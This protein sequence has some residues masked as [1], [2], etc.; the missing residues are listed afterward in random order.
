MNQ[1]TNQQIGFVACSSWT[2]VP[3]TMLTKMR[4][5]YKVF[6]LSFNELQI[7]KQVLGSLKLGVRPWK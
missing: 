4:I 3:H 5:N 6:G 1:P 2:N 7:D